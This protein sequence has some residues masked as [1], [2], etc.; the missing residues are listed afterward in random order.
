M[1]TVAGALAAGVVLNPTYSQPSHRGA[2]TKVFVALG[3]CAIIPVSHA[4][5]KY[6]FK[7]LSNQMGFKWLLL[8]GVL[9]L[10]GAI[11]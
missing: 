10:V 11:I 7:T 6:G 1:I 2:R 4:I 9:Y 5:S 3:L 8:S